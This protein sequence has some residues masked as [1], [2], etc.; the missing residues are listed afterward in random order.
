[1]NSGKE[2]KRN[3]TQ[4]PYQ[5][6][7]KTTTFC[8]LFPESLK[9]SFVVCLSVCLSVIYLFI[10]GGGMPSFLSPYVFHLSPKLNPLLVFEFV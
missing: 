8:S 9:S 4:E 2:K 1:M 3:L 5:I 6:W 7:E 10:C